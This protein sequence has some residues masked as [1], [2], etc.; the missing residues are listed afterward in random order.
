MLLAH[1]HPID[2]QNKGFS[3][4]GVKKWNELPDELKMLAKK[5]FKKEFKKAL[6]DFL[7]T[8]NSYI[9]IDA[10]TSKLKH[11]KIKKI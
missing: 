3:R 1:Q 9:E 5:S 4:V 7:N 11:H 8:E 6:L 2:L 10:I